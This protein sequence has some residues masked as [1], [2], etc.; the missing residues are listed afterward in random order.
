M[1]HNGHCMPAKMIKLD[2]AAIP[3]RIWSSKGGRTQTELSTFKCQGMCGCALATKTQYS[4]PKK[5]QKDRTIIYDLWLNLGEFEF[6]IVLGVAISGCKEPHGT[7]K[8]KFSWFKLYNFPQ[9][10]PMIGK[11]KERVFPVRQLAISNMTGAVPLCM[12]HAVMA[13]IFFD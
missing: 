13:F 1:I 4:N 7:C 3:R 2:P 10:N 8:N 12:C 9:S 11:S 5:I 6:S